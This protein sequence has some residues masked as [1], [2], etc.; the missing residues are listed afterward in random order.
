MIS[1]QELIA[2]FETICPPE[3]AEDWDNVG[4][5]LGDRRRKVGRVMT[6]LTVTPETATEAVARGA[7]LVVS[8]H[9]FPFRADRKWTTETTT[10]SILLTLAEGKVAVYSPHT[11]H[12]SALA[13]VN[14]QLAEKLGLSEIVPLLPGKTLAV[15]AM[16]DGLTDERKDTLAE[17]VGSPLGSGRI[18][19]FRDPPRLSEVSAMVRKTLGLTSLQV[20]GEQETI[21][22]TMAVACGAADDFIP[23]A[24]SEGADALLVGEARFHAA[25]EAK[26]AGLALIVPGHFATERFAMITFAE[27]IKACFPEIDVFPCKKE[28]DPFRWDFGPEES[29]N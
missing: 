8:H 13:G 15:D 28:Q 29:L 1:L 11:A 12:D 21:I 5:L 22:T 14:R 27:R 17:E 9:P 3:L 4:L 23:K 2:F 6:C 25:L 16:L 10:G 7:D 18:G 19:I 20:V 26:A 24:I